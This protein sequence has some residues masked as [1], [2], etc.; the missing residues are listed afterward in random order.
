MKPLNKQMMVLAAIAL[1]LV[2]SGT[3]YA[4]MSEEEA[5]QP[6]KDKR[7]QVIKQL[8]LTPQQEAQIK[9]LQMLNRQKAKELFLRL[10]EERKE[11]ADELDKARS[12]PIKIRALIAE[13][14]DLQGRLIEQ[15]VEDVLKMKEILTPEQYQKFNETL[16]NMRKKNSGLKRR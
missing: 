10:K 15:R 2:F 11:L 8:N 3:A 16:K 14:K 6:N 12:N 9:Q 4:K 5:G 7:D 13:L 1:G